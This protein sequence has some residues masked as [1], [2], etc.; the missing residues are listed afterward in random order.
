MPDIGWFGRAQ[1]QVSFRGGP[2]AHFFYGIRN[3]KAMEPA[4]RIEELIAPSLEHAGFRV[5]RVRLIGSG[6]HTL[7]IMAE[8]VDGSAMSVE[9]C[10]EVSRLVSAILD[11]EDPING[12]Y[13]LEVSS[14]G[15]DRPLVRPED[16]E[17]FSGFEIKLETGHSKDG[18]RRYRGRLLG[19]VEDCVRIA[20]KG[21]SGE[22]IFDISIDDVASA[23]LLLTDDLIE[24]SLAQ[25]KANGNG[26]SE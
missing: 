24:A 15:I 1:N 16:F 20:A 13:M 12:S 21:E 9:H 19:Y 23:K 3:V 4:A 5:V 10:A 26:H 2:A 7:Q 22:E 8:P 18:R 14:P 6:R 25:G 11:V 17:R